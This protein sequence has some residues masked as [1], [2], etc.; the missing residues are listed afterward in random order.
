MKRRTVA[1][2]AGKLGQ[3]SV[4]SPGWHFSQETVRLILGQ[5]YFGEYENIF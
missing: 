1:P 4:S 5:F 2:V 3:L